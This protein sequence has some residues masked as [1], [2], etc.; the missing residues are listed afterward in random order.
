[1]GVALWLLAQGPR[2]SFVFTRPESFQ[3]GLG[4]PLASQGGV[5]Q[6]RRR[7]FFVGIPARFRILAC[8]PVRFPAGAAIAAPGGEPGSRP[9][10][11]RHAGAKDP[12]GSAAHKARRP[13]RPSR[14]RAPARSRSGSRGRGVSSAVHDRAESIEAG[15]LSPDHRPK[16]GRSKHRHSHGSKTSGYHSGEAAGHRQ[17]ASGPHV[18]PAQCRSGRA[19]SARRGG[20]R[21][22]G[23]CAA[24]AHSHRSHRAAAATPRLFP[25]FECGAYSA[26]PERLA[27][28]AGLGCSRNFLRR[29]RSFPFASRARD[30]SRSF[31]AP[32]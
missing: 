19:K 32:I 31:P 18:S 15:Q 2:P 26:Q 6:A 22:A 20:A 21:N 10:L 16:F 30:S 8:D 24:T 28:P 14:T 25:E 7:L 3:D 11:H 13:G 29:V 4:F 27:R 12:A 5:A 23:Q 1:M 9:H 17:T